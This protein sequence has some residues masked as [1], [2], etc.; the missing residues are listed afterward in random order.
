ME[1]KY[2]IHRRGSDAHSDISIHLSITDAPV[3]QEEERSP[4]GEERAVGGFFYPEAASSLL[5]LTTFPKNLKLPLSLLS[6]VNLC[7]NA[8]NCVIN[9]C[10]N[11]CNDSEM[12]RETMMVTFNPFR[13]TTRMCLGFAPTPPCRPRP[14]PVP[15]TSNPGRFIQNP[16]RR[17]GI[18]RMKP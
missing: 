9:I 13:N 15:K 11:L 5:L 6:F 12:I 8:W 10:L 4:I 7:K 18:G 1:E 14:N 17:I 2:L 16:H 3:Y